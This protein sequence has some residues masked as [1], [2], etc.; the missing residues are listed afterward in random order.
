MKTL[1]KCSGKSVLVGLND[2]AFYLKEDGEAV[3]LESPKETS[4]G[5][6]NKENPL[7]ILG[8]AITSDESSKVWCA[9]SRQNKTLALYCPEESASPILVH[10]TQKRVGCM[11]FWFSPLPMIIAGDMVG[12]ATAYPLDNKNGSNGR[13]L[14]GHTAS[15]LTGLCAQEGRLVT[16]DRDEKIRISKFPESFVLE[17]YLLGHTAFVS[18][19]D[20]RND[21]CIS[22]SADQTI[23]LWDLKSYKQLASLDTEG[24]LLPI[25][26]A[27]NSDGTEAAVVY[28]ESSKVDIFKIEQESI[29]KKQ[30]L[31]CSAQPLAVSMTMDD[32]KVLVLSQDPN[33]LVSYDRKEDGS[34]YV[35]DMVVHESLKKAG[36][37]ITMPTSILESDRN[38]FKMEKVN[39]KRGANVVLPWHRVERIQKSKDSRTRRNKRRRAE[40]RNQ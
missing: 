39:E 5:D 8:V 6:Q 24:G 9:V 33:Y 21:R 22:T 19:I 17:E 28:S 3:E 20:V 30:T 34:S 25:Q 29:S 10:K 2:K 12:D 36:D 1:L 38:G 7:E 14:M 27:M 13:F 32:S 31:E 23:R 11:T 35:G 40:G 37:G 18:S 4:E 16:C 26:V 15:M